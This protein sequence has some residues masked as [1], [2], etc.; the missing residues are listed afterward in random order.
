MNQQ[1]VAKAEPEDGRNLT[2][3][4]IDR[5]RLDIV[6]C[7]FKPGEK[8]RIQSLCERYGTNA[9]AIRE[10]L[11]RLVTE[12]LV[13]ALDHR[14][15]RASSVSRDDLLDLTETR[16]SVEC[17]AMERSIAIGD[18]E[19]ES[20]VLAAYHRLSKCTL[21]FE[22]SS[23]SIPAPWELL[24]RQFH[25]A[26]ISGCRSKW[27]LTICSALF[28][29]SERYRHIA[30]NY[31]SPLQRDSLAEHRELMEAA[32]SRDAALA[33]S[34]LKDHFNRT[35]QVILE[36]QDSAVR[37]GEDLAPLQGGLL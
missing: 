19:W 12:Q 32:L 11:S 37:D 35:T 26:L 31:T 9:S 4:V 7:V 1:P 30:N 5:L 17:L 25:E 22:K 28:E 36:K 16:I 10:A 20:Q 3:I 15:Y 24:H 33:C 13:V 2:S 8:L 29:K 6:R 27:L 23:G 14:G 18:A 21:P 34:R